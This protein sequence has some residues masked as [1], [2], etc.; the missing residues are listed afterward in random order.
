M[1]SSGRPVIHLLTILCVSLALLFAADAN[2]LTV[3]IYSG[4]A[5]N[6]GGGAPYSGLVDSFT[7]TDIMF[8]TNTNY[9]W[10]PGE[11]A[12]FGAD[13]T[14]MLNVAAGGTYSFGL[15]SDD[16]SLLFI[17]GN[18][19]VDN[20]N[21]HGPNTAYGSRSLNAGTHSF[22]VQFFEDFGGPSGVDLYLPAGVSYA[23]SVPEPATMAL[24]GAG[25]IGIAALRKKMK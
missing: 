13:I 15:N 11:L 20:G 18:L 8:A 2:A 9:Q 12:V 4:H 5:S 3:D 25:L 10:H 21:A 14:G 19:V 22:E 24:F 16:G 17:D 6:Q 1:N 7:S 23:N